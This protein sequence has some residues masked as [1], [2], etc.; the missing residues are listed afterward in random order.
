MIL[1]G[2]LLSCLLFAMLMCNGAEF[3]ACN[4]AILILLLPIICLYFVISG[5]PTWLLYKGNSWLK[6]AGY[7]Y[8]LSALLLIVP[9]LIF[10]YDWNPATANMRPEN[11]PTDE[12]KYITDNELTLLI[13]AGWAVLLIVPVLTTS[14]LAKRWIVKNIDP[15]R[16]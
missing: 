4:G 1:C 11:I 10:L 14:Y 13:C 16:N 7:L 2:I 12:G 9:L 15:Y 8:L 5:I 6:L 3:E